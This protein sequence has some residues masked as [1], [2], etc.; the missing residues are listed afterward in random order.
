MN[1]VFQLPGIA[2][3]S[4]SLQH[5]L[6]GFADQR[7][8]QIQALAVDAEK[9]FGERQ[10]V[11]HPLTQCRQLK[12]TFAEVVIEPLMEFAGGDGLSQVDAGGSDQTHVHRTWL[13]GADTGDFVVFQGG[14]QFDLD[15][16][17]Q[18]ADLIQVQRAAVGRTEPPGTTAG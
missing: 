5:L 17:W 12:L 9:V 7:H 4:V 18:V 16:Q 2:R 15:R 6:C 10:D 8:R 11:A 13:M 1:D 3:P 14:E